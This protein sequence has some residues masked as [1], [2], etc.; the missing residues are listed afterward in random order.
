MTLKPDSAEISNAGFKWPQEFSSPTLT[1]GFMRLAALQEFLSFDFN[2]H[3]S[4][5]V[6]EFIGFNKSVQAGIDLIDNHFA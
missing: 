5:I 1:V 4:G 6:L 3:H 2:R